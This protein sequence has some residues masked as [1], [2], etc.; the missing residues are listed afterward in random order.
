MPLSWAALSPAV[1]PAPGWA[2]GRENGATSTVLQPEPTTFG[3]PV[4]PASVSVDGLLGVV[5]LPSEALGGMSSS[6]SV[7]VVPAGGVNSN[8]RASGCAKSTAVKPTSNAGFVS[9]VE[10]TCTRRGTRSCPSM[11]IRTDLTKVLG[12]FGV[13]TSSYAERPA[14]DA[15]PEVV[16]VVLSPTSARAALAASSGVRGRLDGNALGTPLGRTPGRCLPS[17]PAPTW[18]ASS[19]WCTAVRSALDHNQRSLPLWMTSDSPLLP[20]RARR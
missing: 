16:M 11:A 5:S 14:T 18:S 9:F 15:V 2:S 13:R 1:P 4:R 10:Y 6:D 19:S 12:S 3:R 8:C 20:I 17:V 7:T